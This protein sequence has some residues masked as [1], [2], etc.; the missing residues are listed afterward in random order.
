LSLFTNQQGGIID[1]L[2]VTKEADSLYVVTNAACA[3]KDWAYMQEQL[4]RFKEQNKDA[5]VKIEP[6]SD[7]ALL[8]LQGPKAATVLERILGYSL[9]DVGFMTARNI[10]L[11][12]IPCHLAR[13]GYTGEDGFEIAVPESKAA[14][15]AELLVA[16]PEVALAGLGARDSLRLEAGMCLYGHDLDETT[17]PIEAGLLWTIGKRRRV[18][19]G[20]PGFERI[21]EQ[22]EQGV[23]RRRVG[24]IVEGAPA[25]EGATILNTEGEV[26]GT[27]T[28]GCPS[29]SLKKN[30]AMGY[31][32][33]EFS[34]VGTPL[35][36]QV[37]QRVQPA[38]IVKMPFVPNRYHKI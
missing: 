9:A 20:F 1:D 3:E 5:D 36:V 26:I 14:R 17:T 15:I 22:I 33:K 35:Q 11:D 16:Q 19:G 37:R 7:H 28:S 31:V 4:N 6:I 34:K 32:K 12:G 38:Q 29:P 24:L 13:G 10:T 18:E 2:I 8:A 27:V 23:T 30:I 25:R 21:R